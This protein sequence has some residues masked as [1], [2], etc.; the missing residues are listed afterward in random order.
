MKF[1]SIKNFLAIRWHRTLW[2]L[3]VAMLFTA[4]GFSSIFPFLPLYVKFLGSTTGMSIE[5]LAGMVYSVQ[6]FTMMIASPI[7]GMLADKYGRKLMV[8]RS[9]FGGA[10]IVLLMAFVRSG[11]EL[12]ILRAIQGLI[13][14]SVAASSALVASIAPKDRTGYAMGVLQVG[15]GSGI[16]LGPMLGGAIADTF[17]YSA[18]FYITSSLLFFAGLIVLFGIQEDFIPKGRSL[19]VKK[20]FLMKYRQILSTPGVLTTYTTRFLSRL[21]RMT[22]IPIIPLF[23]Q[24]L[25]PEETSLNTFTGL[26]IGIAAGSTTISAIVLGRLGDKIGHR[27][28]LI[29]SAL[30]AGLLYFPQSLITEGWHLLFLYTLVGAAMGGLITSISALLAQYTSHGDEGTVYG[31]DNSI[32]ASARALAPLLGSGI[33]VWISLR[34][35]FVFTALIF[36]LAGFI[37]TIGLPK[38][39]K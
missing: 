35:S 5:F 13:T 26:V 4:V 37:A 29:S 31:L 27:K 6:G 19:T 18:T 9:M 12:I 39:P 17:G 24:I 1:P 15:M 14:G 32:Q 10:A 30:M 2:I 7:W 25:L 8:E 20:R 28:V 21:G 33:T 38:S 22:V 36:F 23:I 34:A 3:F 11:E 16:A